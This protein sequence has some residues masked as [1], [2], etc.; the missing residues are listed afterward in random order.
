MPSS[1][2]RFG[3]YELHERLGAGGM[4]EV[5]RAH[6]SE[7]H[8]DVAIK[9]LSESFASDPRR[10][11]RFALEARALSALNHPNILTIH[12]VGEV[13]GR[14][15]IVTECV[16]G[17]TLRAIIHGRPLACRRLLDIGVQF[18]EGLAR[19]HAA[20]VVHRDLKPDN[21]MVTK[22]GVVKIVDFGLAKPPVP[23]QAHGP[24][25]STEADT[26]AGTP[27]TAEG[28]IL[29]T[30]GYMSPEQARGEPTDHRSDQF[31]L[32]AILYEMATGRR[33]FQRDSAVQTLADII[34]RDPEPIERLNP[35]CPPPARW[36]I[37][38]CLAKQPADRYAST[39]DLTH[40]L[41]TVRD[42]FAETPGSTPP[43]PPASARVRHVRAWQAVIVVLAAAAAFVA[44]PLRR[45]AWQWLAGAPMPA[46]RRVVVLPIRAPGDAG[47]LAK[48]LLE[49][50]VL[51]L[52]D[53][54]VYDRDLSVVPAADVVESGVKSP[55]AARTRLGATVAVSISLTRRDDGV[56]VIVS[57]DDAER[58]RLI[59]G[60]TFLVPLSDYTPDRIA[61]EVLE[62]LRVRLKPAQRAAWARGVPAVA[63]AAV[64][65]AQ[66]LTPYQQARAALDRSE[67]E[68]GLAQAIDWFNKAI[69]VDPRYAAAWAGLGEAHLR[70]Y[71]L[72]KRAESLALAER[73]LQRALQ[74][75]DTRPTVWI[76]LGMLNVEKGDT[77]AATGAFERA[78][79]GNPAGA[80]AYRELGLAYQQAGQP[81]K[82]EAF[83]L[84][85]IALQPDA[86]SN[87][88]SLGFLRYE[89]GR[90]ADAAA[91]F[92]RA[93]ALAEDNA[94][95][96]SNLGGVYMAMRR[97]DLAETALL[98]ATAVNPGYGPAWS[99]LAYSQFQHGR[100]AE[101]AASFEHAAALSPRDADIWRNLG[102]AL[103]Y[104]TRDHQR[105]KPAY[106]KAA[107]LLEEER[108][109]N[110]SNPHTLVRL[111]D[112]YE[113]L[114]RPARARALVADALARRPGADDLRQGASVYERLGDR[115]AALRVVRAALDAG[116]PLSAVESSRSLDRLRED[117]RYQAIARSAAARRTHPNR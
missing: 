106:E 88:S 115:V 46:E 12:D 41:R 108:S 102:S 55:S 94:R 85:A 99:N 67:E 74:F 52:A 47:T 30:M 91:Q 100:Y 32:G 27:R 65:F 4:G 48:G 57:L 89:Q 3:R 9:F 45:P 42:H 16:E 117:P 63:E 80:D 97:W 24:V 14:P 73:A 33:A 44:S 78:I 15:Y 28:A 83:Y 59:G 54:N 61:A 96:W 77:A 95:L 113:S 112:C 50:V 98:K 62:V 103:Y 25:A 6:D 31:S 79:A 71:R 36:L 114:D 20:G 75:D 23:L 116:L 43:G 40:E 37:G 107:H 11:A 10:L 34:D 38:R 72:T 104:A 35:S 2:L 18:A 56:Q 111:A 109:V 17:Q 22:D 53:L 64:L 93:L 76:A 87:H 58:V 1:G 92:E 29:G 66:G 81:A 7:L 110:P 101:A 86:W 105:S 60:N 26:S 19:A 39:D 21:V 49:Y 8:R 68:S 69:D 51:R 84:R 82:A 13:D 70:M 5:F 90:L